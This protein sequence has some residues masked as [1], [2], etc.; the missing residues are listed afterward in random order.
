M[1]IHSLGL[2][3]S[4][5]CAS[6][7]GVACDL[8]WCFS[9]M[10]KETLEF[11]SNF[12][13]LFRTFSGLGATWS[14]SGTVPFPV[15]QTILKKSIILCLHT[16]EHA[17]TPTHTRQAFYETVLT[18]IMCPVLLNSFHA[19]QICCFLQNEK[20]LPSPSLTQEAF[21]QFR[22]V[23]LLLQSTI[24]YM[25]L[26]KMLWASS[27]S[28]L[29]DGPGTVGGAEWEGQ[30]H[31][32]AQPVWELMIMYGWV[33]SEVTY[34]REC[35]LLDRRLPIGVLKVHVGHMEKRGLATEGI[36]QKRKLL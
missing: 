13:M 4:S 15:L 1:Y 23:P 22:T 20:Y 27:P 17:H 7:V 29:W 6:V 3:F 26:P 12:S 9:R 32:I 36:W 8:G 10:R 24:G 2:V 14:F 16:H 21:E 33:L 11:S 25:I 31:V 35:M 28:W 19:A 5:H 18:F 30:W 34:I